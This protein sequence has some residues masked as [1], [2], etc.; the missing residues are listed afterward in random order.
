MMNVCNLWKSTVLLLGLSSMLPTVVS[1]DA[2]EDAV[3]TSSVAT[4]KQRLQVNF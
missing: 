2:S 4:E 3:A 1:C